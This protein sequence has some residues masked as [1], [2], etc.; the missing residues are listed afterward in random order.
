MAQAFSPSTQEA[1]AGKSQN[2]RKRKEEREGK[3]RRDCFI[4]FLCASASS[5]DTLA[6]L[7]GLRPL[8]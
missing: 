7:A 5:P 8:K 3:E 2:E 6:S 1:Q 4:V